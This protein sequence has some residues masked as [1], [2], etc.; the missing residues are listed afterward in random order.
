MTQ[1][2]S[3]MLLFFHGC[4]NGAVFFFC[5]EG[6]CFL[7]LQKWR[8]Y[9]LVCCMPATPPTVWNIFNAT[10]RICDRGLCWCARGTILTCSLNNLSILYVQKC[11]TNWS[12][13][14]SCRMPGSTLS[15]EFVFCLTVAAPLPHATRMRFR[16]L[17]PP[18]SR[19]LHMVC[20]S[21]VVPT[22]SSKMI[23]RLVAFGFLAWTMR[24][25]LLV[26]VA[27]YWE[28]QHLLRKLT[29]YSLF[30]YC[31]LFA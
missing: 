2:C 13:T 12:L 28:R 14:T 8:S 1:V 7:L 20:K 10:W 30:S 18:R 31:A 3:R 11:T 16:H 25:C 6:G 26:E 5:R 9:W 24:A 17:L 29:Q 15:F 19:T 4:A 23:L 27:W 21:G 22:P